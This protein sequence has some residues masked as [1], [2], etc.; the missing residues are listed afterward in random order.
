MNRNKKER[1][2]KNIN[3]PL[4]IVTENVAEESIF[5]GTPECIE[6]SLEQRKKDADKPLYLKRI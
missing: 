1:F 3:T 4:Q 6:I 5:V 2:E